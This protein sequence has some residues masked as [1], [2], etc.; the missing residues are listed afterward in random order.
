[1]HFFTDPCFS[2]L[3]TRQPSLPLRLIMACICTSTLQEVVEYPPV[4]V[5]AG[6]LSLVGSWGIDNINTWTSVITGQLY[7]SGTYV[8][9]SSSGF[10]QIYPVWNVFNSTSGADGVGGAWKASNYEPSDGL[11]K[12]ENIGRYSLD[13]SYYGDWVTIQ[14]PERTTMTSCTF[15]GRQGFVNR[16]PSKFKVLFI[17]FCTYL[18]AAICNIACLYPHTLD[19]LSMIVL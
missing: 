5:A 1:M 9:K 19:M 3:P 4:P 11:F 8:I 10:S 12:G 13:G 7:G 17:C 6:S 18:C 15:V 14:L 16:A 2:S